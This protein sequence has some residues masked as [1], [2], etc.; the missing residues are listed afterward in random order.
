MAYYLGRDVKVYIATEKDGAGLHVHDT[1]L[2]ILSASTGG[3]K[4]ASDRGTA[5]NASGQ[6]TDLTGVDLGLSATDEDI[7]FIGLRTVLKAEVKKETT[8]SLTRK[9]GDAVWDVI[10]NGDG[11]NSGRWGVSGV[12]TAGA[13]ANFYTGLEK[14]TQNY[15][16]R[17]HIQLKASGEIFCL[18]NAQI[19]GH[20]TSVSADGVSEET[21]EFISQVDPKIVTAVHT[22]ITPT[23]DL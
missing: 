4:F 19:S 11:T 13:T 2:T 12:V 23:T 16:Y 3:T 15:G 18:R 17:L 22:T 6:V 9:K 14:P 1:N 5:M 20:T 10:F 8:L 7:S 21:L